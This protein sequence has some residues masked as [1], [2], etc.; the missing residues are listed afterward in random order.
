MKTG[1]NVKRIKKKKESKNAL[2]TFKTPLRR[3]LKLG[4]DCKKCGHCCRHGSGALVRM[5][6]KEI[7]KKL[8]MKEEEIKEK[9]MEEIERFN[10]KLLRP[11]L[12]REEG[13]PYGRCIFL[14]PDNKCSIYDVRPLQC[15]ISSC[16][17]YGEQLNLWFMLNYF[18]NENDPES[19]RQYAIYI[20]CGG[21]IL[22][23]AEIDNLIKD[24]GKLRKIIK[25]E[26]LK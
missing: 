20:R 25:Y 13:R 26:I 2:I 8:N 14:K 4:K 18:L 16:S 7:A 15:K 21:K 11:K 3:I 6:L 5:E 19:I 23:G 22:K 24:K 12:I 17:E 9:Y 1:N 10:T